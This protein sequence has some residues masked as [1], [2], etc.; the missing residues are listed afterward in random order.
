MADPMPHQPSDTPVTSHIRTFAGDVAL[1][2]GKPLP[3]VP[4]PPRPLPE[5]PPGVIIPQAP[6]THE[7]KEEVLARLKAKVAPSAPVRDDSREAV[8]NRL[9]E[10]A[11]EPPLPPGI[12]EVK[13]AAPERIHTYKSDFSDHASAKGATRIS[14]LAA[15][16]DAAPATPV[17][18][19]KKPTNALA[20]VLGAVLIVAG[21]GAVYAAYRFAT[22][23]PSI[24]EEVAVAS[25]IFA[26]ERMRLQGS[27]EELRTL[28]ASGASSLKEGDAAVAYLVYSTTTEDGVVEVVANGGELF[29]ALR[30]PAPSLLL[31][32]IE[33]ESTIGLVNEGGEARPFFIFKVD[34]YE[35]SF[36]GMLDW[37]ATL[38]RDLALFYPPHPAEPIGSSTATSTSPFRLSFIDE[39]E[40]NRDVRVLRD[41]LGR[42]VM[43][44]GFYD[45]TVLVL[46]RD[47]AAFKELVTRLSSTR[48]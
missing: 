21:I 6:T 38:E 40:E 25:L 7:S 27:A 30:L 2:T 29:E 19:E 31:R 5:P 37:E 26:D 24:P 23:E 28:L 44:Y 22:G 8:L 41:A 34:S 32:A 17:L 1:L 3:H 18:Q 15:Q 13:K 14:M 45:K 20:F 4:A 9:K 39:V 33:P 36:A 16:A 10:R 11:I 47:E 35:R 12:P 48:R 43:L 42:T 46:A